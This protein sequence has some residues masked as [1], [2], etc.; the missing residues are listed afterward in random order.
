MR[1]LQVLVAR[2]PLRYGSPLPPA[3]PTEGLRY[4]DPAS[5][6]RS[7]TAYTTVTSQAE[8]LAGSQ[9]WREALAGQLR[10]CCENNRKP[11]K[12]RVNT[13]SRNSTE[14]ATNQRRRDAEHKTWVKRTK[15]DTGSH[16][17]ACERLQKKE[18]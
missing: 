3:P 16:N 12:N 5:R 2:L 4:V 17:G 11:E 8:V 15:I 7:G 9:H 13:G 6:G 1:Q 14:R 10:L 18:R